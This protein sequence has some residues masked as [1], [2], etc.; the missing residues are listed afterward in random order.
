MLVTAAVSRERGQPFVVEELELE[1]PR[2]D[3]VLVRVVGAGICHTDLAF[4]DRSSPLPVV[5]GHGGAGVVEQVGERVA[6]VR[7]A[8]TSC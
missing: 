6:T 8:I 1:E 4:R 2:G 5:L 7:P 3:E